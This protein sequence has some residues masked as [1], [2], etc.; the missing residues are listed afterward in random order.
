MKR[1]HFLHSLAGTLAASTFLPQILSAREMRGGKWTKEWIVKYSM[2]LVDWAKADLKKRAATLKQFADI[3]APLDFKFFNGPLDKKDEAFQ[4]KFLSA[5]ASDKDT[6]THIAGFLK[7]VETVRVS[8]AAKENEAIP[9]W[10]NDQQG[11]MPMREGKIF[12]YSIS[13]RKLGVI[14]DNSDS[15]RPYL[16]KLRTEIE[17]DF[18]NCHTVEVDGCELTGEPIEGHVPWFY[19]APALGINPFTPDRHCPSIP[20]TEAHFAWANWTMDAPSAFV[21]MTSLM[22][23]DAIYWFC[24]F[25]DPISDAEVAILGKAILEKKIKLVVHTLNKNPPKSLAALV[26]RTEGKVIKKRLR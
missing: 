15:M 23:V 5:R 20:Q 17:R 8:I 6:T 3:E 7:D 25:D 11:D 12:D 26:E 22:G 16:D 14:L 21:A 13:S 4:Q 18:A 19:A 1:R 10:K 24:D 2:S 9:K